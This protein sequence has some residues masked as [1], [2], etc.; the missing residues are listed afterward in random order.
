MQ[1]L[2]FLYVANKGEKGR[3]IYTGKAI[4]EGDVIEICPVIVIPNKEVELIH[5]TILHDYYFVWGEDQKGC[6]ITLGYGSLY[7]HS[8][9]ANTEFF[10]DYDNQTID[11]ICVKDIAPGEEITVNYNG[12]ANDEKPVWFDEKIK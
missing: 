1:Q 4:Y 5:Q 7:N 11:F 9:S 8:Y 12:D 6:A 2:P 10:L 3:G